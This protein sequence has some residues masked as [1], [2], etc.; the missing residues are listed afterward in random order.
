MPELITE[1]RTGPQLADWHNRD[2]NQDLIGFSFHDGYEWIEPLKFNVTNSF[3][4]W[5]NWARKV[6]WMKRDPTIYLLRQIAISGIESAGWH[7]SSKEE[8]DEEILDFAKAQTKEIHSQVLR[9]AGLGCY[10]YGWAVFERIYKYDKD[11]RLCVDRLKNLLQSMTIIESDEDTGAFTGLSQEDV[12]LQ[13]D[14]CLLFNFDV[15]GTN[16]YGRSPM[17]AA[18]KPFDSEVQIN[19]SRHKLNRRIAAS[20]WLVYYPVGRT[21]TDDPSLTKDDEGKASNF[22][23]ANRIMERLLENGHVTLP[24]EIRSELNIMNESAGSAD[25]QAW[26]VELLGGDSSGSATFYTDQLRYEDAL[27]ARAFG[28]PERAI[29]E[30]QYGTKAEAESHGDVAIQNLEQRNEELAK[31]AN[32][33]LQDLI[34]FNFGEEMRDMVFIQAN[35]L[36]DRQKLQFQM[37]WDKFTQSPEV[38]LNEYD[39]TDMRELRD[40]LMIPTIEES[41]L[42]GNLAIMQE[43]KELLQSDDENQPADNEAK[44]DDEEPNESELDSEAEGQE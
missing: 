33:V 37:I 34:A 6:E 4:Y 10:D 29:L 11:G 22:E 43:K 8:I 12:L 35:P 13:P 25:Y 23:I 30:G 32:P 5:W 9:Q 21:P 44:N 20:H 39:I 24:N 19:A 31:S 15:E 38:L 3:S 1:T 17:L 14:E 26:R 40:K 7:V 27:K 42:E 18:Q 16:W 28:F 2:R 41:E 36:I